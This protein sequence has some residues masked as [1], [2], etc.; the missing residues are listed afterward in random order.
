MMY[1]IVKVALQSVLA[2]FCGKGQDQQQ[3]SLQS[4]KGGCTGRVLWL[5]LK[6]DNGRCEPRRF[7]GLRCAAAVW[8]VTPKRSE[9][10]SVGG[11]GCCCC[12]S[13]RSHTR[14]CH[15]SQSA[16]LLL[17]FLPSSFLFVLVVTPS[18]F[19]AAVG[20]QEQVEKRRTS[21]S[22]GC[23]GTASGASRTF[24]GLVCF[25]NSWACA[26]GF[27]TFQ[28]L[29]FSRRFKIRKNE[30]QRRF[31][32]KICQLLPDSEMPI[33]QMTR[34]AL[35]N[36]YARQYKTLILRKPY[37]SLMTLL[38]FLR[39]AFQCASP[40]P[41]THNTSNATSLPNHKLT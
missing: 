9:S 7:G 34:N 29:K 18:G 14:T 16:L 26:G 5:A 41:A 8:G 28:G 22:C 38:R 17:V 24:L 32:K 19:S 36:V 23:L 4:R 15:K 33:V 25:K 21:C 37:L 6:P 20:R 13:S 31:N 27:H 35:R 1:R 2:E 30:A 40:P 12:W 11:F 3:Q 10:T 39:F